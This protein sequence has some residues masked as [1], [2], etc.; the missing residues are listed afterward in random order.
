LLAVVVAFALGAGIGSG[1]G[2]Q[3][4]SNRIEVYTG[5]PE[6]Q[7]EPPTVRL[8]VQ[9]PDSVAE[10]LHESRIADLERRVAMFEHALTAD[11][12]AGESTN[13]EPDALEDSAVPSDSD[14]LLSQLERAGFS[15]A[16]YGQIQATRDRLRLQR[17]QLRDKAIREG[18]FRS[19]AWSRQLE[20]IDPDTE[21]RES[22]GDERFD[23]YLLATGQNNRV[24]VEELMAGSAAEQAGL[25][26]GDLLYR[27]ADVRVFSSTELRRL[28]TGGQ[29]GENT[30]VTVLRN[31]ELV[32][33]SIPRGPLGVIIT[34][35]VQGAPASANN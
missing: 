27:Y 3:M 35:V 22:L 9:T 14:Q 32:D 16:E 2:Y 24:K 13:T 19:E 15:E 26:A 29:A 28:T 7:P 31:G 17:L 4:G 5:S 25:E 12:S 20:E 23:E 11:T 30:A 10:S 8:P 1:F 34:G 18:W 21:L 6:S 33:L